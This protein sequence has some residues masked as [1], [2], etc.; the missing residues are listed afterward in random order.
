MKRVLTGLA[1]VASMITIAGTGMAAI[2][3]TGL[4]AITKIANAEFVAAHAD[5]AQHLTG[6]KVWQSGDD[7]RVKIYVTHNGMPME[8]NFLC[9]V[10][11]E[12]P[13]CHAQ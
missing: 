2:D 12:G 3:F 8:F 11:E 10:H 4:Q 13:E 9:H 7:A 5:H 6:F 1:T